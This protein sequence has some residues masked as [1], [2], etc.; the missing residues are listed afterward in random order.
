M[1][2]SVAQLITSEIQRQ[3]AIRFS[4]F[5][6]LALYAPRLGYYETRDP[7]GARGDFYTSASVPL[8]GALLARRCAEWLRPNQ[9]IYEA[10]ANNG[11]LASAVLRQLAVNYTIVEPS[12]A[13]QQRQLE[14][15]SA[16]GVSEKVSW[17]PDLPRGCEGVLLTNELLDAIPFDLW[18]W[19]RSART[20]SLLGATQH[21]VAFTW[22]VLEGSSRP[23]LPW[24]ELPSE[25]LDIVPDGFRTEDHSRAAQWWKE[26]A[27]RLRDGYLVAFDYGLNSED[28]FAPERAQGTFR[29]YAKH[30]QLTNVLDAP[31]EQD[32]TSHV[33][34]TRVRQA[35]EE[36][37]LETIFDGPQ[38]KFLHEIAAEW[39][40]AAPADWT[41]SMARQFQTLTHP[42][43]LGRSFRVLVQRRP[44]CSPPP[45]RATP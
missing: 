38:S 23:Q 27:E 37:G 14:F 2:T 35:G 1:Q 43:H 4:R 25:L 22:S 15:L 19:N 13:Q 16:Q 41:A 26:A 45:P 33:N 40:A 9:G 17:V 28:F 5:M 44:A 6:E 20:W 36:A 10:G 3:G 29:G 42:E 34:F 7:V 11:Q 18:Q 24:I 8:F 32:I 30:R 12:P 39:I 31:G 21:E